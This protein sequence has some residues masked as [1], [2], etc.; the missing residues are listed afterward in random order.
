M[1]KLL[2]R[3]LLLE[4]Y[5]MT[6]KL[7]KDR[8]LDEVREAKERGHED[9]IF[10][11]GDKEFYI[12][13][14]YFKYKVAGWSTQN[15]FAPVAR[16]VPTEGERGTTLS[17]TVRMRAF[18]HAITL[19]LY[20]LFA[21]CFI[22]GATLNVIEIIRDG[23]D[24]R[25]HYGILAFLIFI[26]ILELV[27]HFTYRKPAERLK[28]YLESLFSGCLMRTLFEIDTKDYDLT[29][30]SKIRPSV[31]AIIIKDGRVA[32]VHSLLYDY[33]KFPGGGI[34]SGESH[35]DALIRETAEET[36]LSVIPESI[37]KYGR[38]YRIQRCEP[39]DPRA[40]IQENFYYICKVGE[41]CAAQNL[42]EYED[43]ERFTLEY[44]LP[45]EAIE[46]NRSAESPS[47]VMREREAR[48]LEL[49][50]SEGFFN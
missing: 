37:R 24:A 4:R 44:V 28:K 30:G 38:V 35:T 21:L 15:S 48:V 42:D 47:A 33:Y 20:L 2:L 46:R 36:G 45:T 7:S 6:T 39:D 25:F 49:L 8:V 18:V 10:K 1:K 12:A 16:I 14:K 29:L 26:P 5:K 3:L 32:M 27:L 11:I 19:F 9:Y 13:E 50:I 31:R 40:F 34:E 22:G 41:Q 17:V 23:S 43:E